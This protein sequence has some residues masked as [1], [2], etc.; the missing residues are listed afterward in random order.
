MGLEFGAPDCQESVGAAGNI[1]TNNKGGLGGND[2]K[3][4]E[5]YD[6]MADRDRM[7]KE[8]TNSREI[9]NLCS[10]IEVYNMNTI[11]SFGAEAANE[12]S[13][14][15]DTILRSVNVSQLDEPDELF[16][17]LA[18][19]MS[20]FDIGEIKDNQSFFGKLFG[21]AKK[22]FDKVLEKYHTMG[23]EVDRIYVRLRSY[24]D[25]IKQSNKKLESL[26]NANVDYYHQLV[27]YILAGEQGCKEIEAYIEQREKDLQN[28]GDNSIQFELTTL[29]QALDMLDKRTHDLKTAELVAL[30]SIPMIKMMEFNNYNLVRKIDSAFIVTLPVFKQ[31]LAQAILLKRQKIQAEAMNELQKKTNQMLVRNRQV[32]AEVA[33]T[34]SGNASGSTTQ[35]E[36]LQNVF[37]T[38][39]SG[40][41]EAKAMQEETRKK[42]AEEQKKLEAIK[43]DFNKKYDQP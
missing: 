23:D 27:K 3:P 42:R 29:R 28:T 40:I 26:F 12:I 35:I 2:L 22:K 17:I 10:K 18:D 4:V 25:E 24:E 13:K 8:L 43:A 9:D 32:Q 31:A 21:N 37:D 6:I 20:R 19:I 15:S 33:G 34:L 39:T 36:T 5:Q 1:N 7:N 14:A 30:Q 41:V 16:R 38:I 11:V